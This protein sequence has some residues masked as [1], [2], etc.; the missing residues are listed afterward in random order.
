I[1]SHIC[2]ALS[3]LGARVV[4]LDD[5]SGGDPTNIESFANVEFVKGTIL[6]QKL[7]D[8]VTRGCDYVFHEAALGSVPGSVAEPRRYY[9]VNCT[10]TLNVLEAARA[11]RVK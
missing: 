5:L 8:E 7:V 3:K 9:D 2:E 10:G 4:V 11:A 6:D 1:G